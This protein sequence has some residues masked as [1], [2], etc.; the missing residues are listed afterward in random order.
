MNDLGN[1]IFVL[2]EVGLGMFHKWTLHNA[3]ISVTS[4]QEIH[5][6]ILIWPGHVAC[7][8]YNKIL[9]LC[10]FED[11]LKGHETQEI[12][13]S[14]KHCSYEHLAST[15]QKMHKMSENT[16]CSYMKL[17][18]YCINRF[19]Q[20]NFDGKYNIG[21]VVVNGKTILKWILEVQIVDIVKWID[22]TFLLG[23]VTMWLWHQL[24]WL[25]T[26]LFLQRLGLIPSPVVGDS[27]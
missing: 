8:K 21:D 9:I 23:V 20:V 24:R 25:V 2:V 14:K 4:V 15:V 1:C 18:I 6:R 12:V 22:L 10:L 27:W 26:G 19:L 13:K 11:H 5:L 3:C 16:K 17:M 7:R